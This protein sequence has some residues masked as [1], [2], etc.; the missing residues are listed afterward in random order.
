MGWQIGVVYSRDGSERSPGAAIARRGSEFPDRRI[1]GLSP[2]RNI[3]RCR[4]ARLRPE[5][6]QDRDWNGLRQPGSSGTRRRGDSWPSCEVTLARSRGR[7]QPPMERDCLCQRRRDH[8]VLEYF[9][10]GPGASSFEDT[11]APSPAW[12]TAPTA[13]GFLRWARTERSACGTRPLR[14]N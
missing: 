8:P 9:K 5:W 12:P 2:S 1:A 4:L 11:R 13:V 7:G 14:G 6:L 3:G 10:P